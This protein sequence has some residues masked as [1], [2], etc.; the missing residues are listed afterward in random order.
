MAVQT[1]TSTIRAMGNGAATV[2]SFAPII[3]LSN[4]DEMH[5]YE[6][7]DDDNEV[8][9]TTGFTV[10]VSSFPGTGD[11]TFDTAPTD[12]TNLLFRRQ[13]EITQLTRLFNQGAFDPQVIER[14]LDKL[15]LIAADLKSVEEDRAADDE[16]INEIIQEYLRLNHTEVNAIIREYI[17]D[18]DIGTGG[19]GNVSAYAYLFTQSFTL[20]EDTTT[21]AIPT[22]GD[23]L[24]INILDETNAGGPII[25]GFPFIVEWEGVL[26]LQI[27]QAREI[28]L[29]LK[30]TH[31][32]NGKTFTHP[33][34]Y[35]F[36]LVAN[37]RFTV[38]LTVFNSH[39]ILRAG[40][41]NI[42]GEEIVLTDADFL[43]DT[44]I[45]YEFEIIARRRSDDTRRGANVTNIEL[46]NACQ[47]AFQL[48]RAVSEGGGDGVDQTARNIAIAAL[49][50][51]GGVMT[52]TL[53]LKGDPAANL[54]AATKQYVDSNAGSGGDGTDQTARDA[55]AAAQSAAD[56]AQSAADDAQTTADAI[57]TV[58]AG[59]R[60]PTGSDGSDEDFWVA[61]ID[62][63]GTLSISENVEGAYVEIGRASYDKATAASLQH[64]T[65]DIH[66]GTITTTWADV[67][68]ADAD[69]F[70]AT[71]VNNAITLTDA[72]F[73]NQGASLTIPATTSP[74]TTYVFVRL[75]AATDVTPLRIVGS[76][77]LTSNHWRLAADE[78]VTVPDNDAFQYWMT[79]I[80]PQETASLTYQLQEREDITH[81]RYDGSLGGE[82]LTQALNEDRFSAVEHLTRD[83][84]VNH[85]NP[86]WEN[87][88][89]DLIDLYGVRTSAVTTLTD[90]NFDSN[91]AVILIAS[92][93]A[94]TVFARLPVAANYLRY[95]VVFPNGL[96][97]AGN[98]WTSVTGPDTTTYQYWRVGDVDSPGQSITKAQFHEVELEDT[99]YTGSGSIPTGGTTGQALVKSTG[100]PYDV[101]WGTV[102]GSG[103]G[104]DTTARNAAA[105]AQATADAALPKA[106]GTMTGKIVLDGAPTANLHAATKAYV[107]ANAGSGGDG[108]GG[109]TTPTV[110]YEDATAH[111]WDHDG[112]REVALSRA[113]AA[114]T[115]LQFTLVSSPTG[116]MSNTI[117]MPSDAFLALDVPDSGA[118]GYNAGWPSPGNK[119][120]LGV[121]PAAVDTAA[122]ITYSVGGN[123]WSHLTFCFVR[124]QSNTR[125]DILYTFDGIDRSAVVKIEELPNG[126]SA[127]AGDGGGSSVTI[128]DT[129]PD[130]IP[131]T[132]TTLILRDPVGDRDEG[133]YVVKSHGGDYYEGAVVN[134]IDSVIAVQANLDNNPNGSISE[135][136]WTLNG[137]HLY[138]EFH[139][140]AFAATPPANLYIEITHLDTAGG[141]IAAGDALSSGDRTNSRVTLAR[142][143]DFDRLG[144]YSYGN[145]LSGAT[146]TLWGGVDVGERLRFKVYTDSGYSTPLV[147]A[148]GKYYD[149]ITED[150]FPRQMALARLAQGGATD[151]QTLVW[152]NNNNVWAPADPAAG[153]GSFTPSKTNL[154]SAVKEIFHPATNSSVTADDT[155]SELDVSTT[156]ATA[157]SAAAAAQLTASTASNAASQ[158]QGTA[159]QAQSAANGALPKSGGTMTG[160]IT[161]DGDP[162]ANLHP[163][164][165]SYADSI[166]RVALA[167]LPLSGG[168]MTGP[169]VLQGAPTVDLQAATKKY[170]DDN[171]GGGGGGG[172]GVVGDFLELIGSSSGSISIATADTVVDT[173]IDLPA[174]IPTTEVWAVR[175]GNERYDD[176]EFFLASEINSRDGT[177]VG[178]MLDPDS[179]AGRAA[180]VL[181]R[182][183][184][185]GASQNDLLL[186]AKDTGASGHIL[187][188]S[189]HQGLDPEVTLYR[190]NAGGGGGG[191][192]AAF[193]DET[194]YSV[195]VS[196]TN[197]FAATGYTAPNSG[198]FLARFRRGD[199]NRTTAFALIDAAELRSRA[200]ST[201]GGSPSTNSGN[202]LPGALLSTTAGQLFLLGIASDG[203]VL[204]ALGSSSDTGG[205]AGT[206]GIREASTGGSGGGSG[207]G[208]GEADQFEVLDTLPSTNDHD[209][210]D[211][212]A[213]GEEFYKL[214]VTD[215]TEPNLF[216]GNVGRDV[217][218]TTAGE[219]WRGISNSQSPN[220]FSTD[221]EFTANPNNTLSLLLASSTRHIRVAMKRSIYEA[222]KGSAF[223]TNDHI[224]IKVTMADGTTTDEAVLAYYNQ[225]IRRDTSGT[226]T[227]YI[228]WQHRH[229]SDNYNLY[230][231][232]AGNAIKIEFFTTSGSTPA[233]TTTP[234][235]TH[236]VALKHWIHWPTNDTPSADARAALNLAQANKARIDALDLHV[237]GD[238]EPLHT[239]TYDEN[240]ALVAPLAGNAGDFAVSETFSDVLTDDLIVVDWRKCDHLNHHD[241]H[242]VPGSNTD[243]GRMYF[244]PRNFDTE[245]WDGEFLYGLERALQDNGS[246]DELN[247]WIVGAI[248]YSG[249]SLTFGLHLQQGGSRTNRN[250]KPRPGFSITVRVYR[251]SSVAATLETSSAPVKG[252]E[253]GRLVGHNTNKLGE[254]PWTNLLTDVTTVDADGPGWSHWLSLPMLDYITLANG[255]GI[256]LEMTRT[257]VS[258]Q[259]SQIFIPWHAMGQWS[260]SAESNPMFGGSWK[261]SGT[262]DDDRIEIRGRVAS[263]RLDLQAACAGADTT[264]TLH[265]YIAK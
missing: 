103:D 134:S 188:A 108:G 204:L 129:L 40:T 254:Q 242:V 151:G 231:E 105:A 84:H 265:A 197:S 68:D 115:V 39:A 83:L 46:V 64:L 51:S 111:T 149:L 43:A 212:I 98:A 221:G 208:G 225:Y 122:R 211:L 180:G 214:A 81:T 249:S 262:S 137:L 175:I 37:T 94:T 74:R 4:V 257:G 97:L 194:Q 128:V 252:A 19:P 60:L 220:G 89:D 2:F 233:A 32:L 166:S 222:A 198:V 7:D 100:D 110:L 62:N 206:L 163:A 91:G 244:Y 250:L 192:G 176:L 42:G 246:Q 106:G 107:D 209:T 109:T 159:A 38:P 223:N 104:T 193:G 53:I 226:D 147:S 179:N 16:E 174:D 216:E 243:A 162:T 29:I 6:I 135:I 96:T 12:G 156:D 138:L 160:K 196:S 251:N 125:M 26:E 237:D 181:I 236:A 203:E 248:T 142:Q 1:S 22:T 28:E 3:L 121:A 57:P 17:E 205:G 5:V 170:V 112:F 21:Q 85:Q 48:R 8:E 228:I 127:G 24:I 10:S 227:T 33:R 14:A 118:T 218:N 75:P 99:T 116:L 155:D 113:P 65:R 258:G 72:N 114:G 144:H 86:D 178:A 93:A 141:A 185:Q 30:T 158:A 260:G 143:A 130:T 50:K 52:G 47:I 139:N 120:W 259:F 148:G 201:V 31:N 119:A 157:R 15:T 182:G 189:T 140:S 247:S 235:L 191:G 92:D 240:T 169:L 234:L 164:T 126:S 224:A 56:A 256:I 69:L 88:T 13:V 238:A 117:Y 152:D 241:E 101:E 184:R 34:S 82:G 36:N 232:D 41:Y 165:K 124:R 71:P 18:N 27:D 200:A 61:G 35:K 255:L 131:D 102:S 195:T 245:E 25:Q 49:P 63:G 77:T 80:N 154:Y 76:A 168:T 230:T 187:I 229:A 213:V 136:E 87:A 150:K 177:T 239:Q 167:A 219:R 70:W 261:A 95:R 58:L 79:F 210:N 263:G 253:L 20:A 153:G 55:A 264:G 59:T 133:V 11:V 207:E 90:A 67:D 9:I 23:G 186:L 190:V 171:A 172:G 123:E 78:G 217:F 146:M 173:G 132:G 73:N 45:S 215:D 145:Q 199:G 202:F 183:K 161:L 44:M 66:V 54:E